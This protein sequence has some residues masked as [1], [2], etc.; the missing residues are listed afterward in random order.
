[1]VWKTLYSKKLVAKRL[2]KDHDHMCG[3]R[4]CFK[5]SIVVG[6]SKMKAT[7]MEEIRVGARATYL[8]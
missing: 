1:M 3:C 7:T 2:I 5:S 4:A 8:Y 6:D